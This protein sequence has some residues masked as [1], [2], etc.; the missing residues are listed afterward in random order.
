MTAKIISA[1]LTL[2][3]VAGAAAFLFIMLLVALNG[4]HGSDANYG[5]SAYTIL[6]AVNVIAMTAAAFV[7]TGILIKREFKCWVAGLISVPVLTIVGIVFELVILFISVLITD[8]A[9]KHF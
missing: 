8:I 1:I 4:F 2:I 6:S 3:A 7:L 5:V 9:S